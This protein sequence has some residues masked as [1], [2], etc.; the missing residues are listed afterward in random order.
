MLAECEPILSVSPELAECVNVRPH[1]SANLTSASIDRMLR[2]RMEEDMSKH[3]DAF[4]RFPYGKLAGDNKFGLTKCPTCGKPP[5]HPTQAE[6][7]R[8]TPI[9]P[10][11]FFLFAD[12]LSAKEYSISGMCQD[13]QNSVFD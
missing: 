12:T 2:R 9:P 10:E 1:P 4:N 7:K 3:P 11:G 13:C 8:N 5:T 6:W